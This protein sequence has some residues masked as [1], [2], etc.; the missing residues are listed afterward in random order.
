MKL[1]FRAR[2][3]YTITKVTEPMSLDSE[4]FRNVEPP[5]KGESEEEFYEYISN[6]LSNW[7]G[8][9]FLENN[10]DKFTE[11]EQQDMWNTFI[12]YPSIEMFD[13][14]YKSDEVV[15]DGGKIDKN[16]TRY[17]GFNP[18]YTPKYE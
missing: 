17:A 6:V 5:F 8:E 9:E 7:E 14:R 16:Y 11:E 1:D 18:I 2:T 13:S 12:E 3:T 4:K 10:K 15:T